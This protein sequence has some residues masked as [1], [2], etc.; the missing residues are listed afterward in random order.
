MKRVLLIFAIYALPLPA[1]ADSITFDGVQN[2]SLSKMVLNSSNGSLTPTLKGYY[3]SQYIAAY[4]TPRLN[5]VSGS[6]ISTSLYADGNA[7]RRKVPLSVP[8]PGTLSLL[9]TGLCVVG[10]ICKI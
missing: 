1:L 4:H 7:R 5:I 6:H 10:E 9:G 8:E 2:S 3:D